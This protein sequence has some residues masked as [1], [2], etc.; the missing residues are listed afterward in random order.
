[1]TKTPYER[2]KYDGFWGN[3]HAENSDGYTR[4]YAKG[5]NIK[6]YIKT[7]AMQ[8]LTKPTGTLVP[9]LTAGATALSVWCFFL[10]LLWVM[11][12]RSS[13]S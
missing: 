7:R 5:T 13:L 8:S 10:Y 6:A 2:G 4:G 3:T 1:M 12:E 9:I 11:Y